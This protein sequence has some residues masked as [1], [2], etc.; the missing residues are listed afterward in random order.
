MDAISQRL[1]GQLTHIIYRN[2]E[3]GYT[4]ARFQPDDGGKP[5]GGGR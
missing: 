2:E 1:K 4:V 5:N 3:N